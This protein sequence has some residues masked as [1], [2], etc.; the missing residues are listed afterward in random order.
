MAAAAL[1]I[2]ALLILL[3]IRQGYD[4]PSFERVEQ[5]TSTEPPAALPAALA[6]ALAAKGGMAGFPAA[7]TL[8][9][10]A[11]RGVLTIH[12]LPRRFGVRNYAVAQVPGKH[13]LADHEAEA[14]TIAFAGSGDA[15]PLSK[16]RARL[17]RGG[18]RFS[19]AVTSD[20]AE[21]GLL[22]P[23]RKAVR[24]RLTILSIAMLFAGGLGAIGV[25]ALIPRYG[26]WPF[27]LPLAVVIA[28]IVG[29]VMAAATTPLSDEGLMQSARWRGFKRYL[30]DVAS[31]RESS[32]GAALR[33][34]WWCTASRSGSATSGRVT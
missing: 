2:V 12:E 25:A 22:D 27:V 13:D 26:G 20:L 21:R 29:V 17:A 28:G 1:F 8:L 18:R 15:V 7:A 5:P 14:L 19:Q 16:A 30:K 3:V 34:R 33:S 10:L 9:D 11:D 6:A 31:S 24:D 23:S 4:A 32:G